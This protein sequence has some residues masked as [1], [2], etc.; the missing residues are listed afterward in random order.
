MEGCNT[1][2]SWNTGHIVTGNVHNPHYYEWLRRNGGGN[3]EREV[4]DIPCGGLPGIYQ[5]MGLLQNRNFQRYAPIENTIHIKFTEIHRNIRDLIDDK[6]PLYPARPN[7][8]INKHLD[9]AYLMNEISEDEWKRRLEIFEAKF[10]R[11]KEIGQILQMFATTASD[12]IRGVVIKFGEVDP[13]SFR[14]WFLE[15]LLQD[16]ERIRL[17]T[18]ETLR[19]LSQRNHMAVPQF[20]DSFRWEA[21]RAFYKKPKRTPSAPSAPSAPPMDAEA[22]AEQNPMEDVIEE[23]LNHIV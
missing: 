1:A 9:V 8:A 15:T 18:N 19:N 16:L 13:V 20:T 17:Y 23:T 14:E 3:A 22:E 10:L 21:I 2:F 7:N 5:V 12:M 11:R 4:G 6:L